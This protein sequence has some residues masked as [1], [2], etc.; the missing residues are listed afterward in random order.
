MSASQGF[1]PVRQDVRAV[2]QMPRRA[3]LASKE[4]KVSLRIIKEPFLL[5]VPSNLAVKTNSD[6]GDVAEG[7]RTHGFIDVGDRGS[8][9]LDAIQKVAHVVGTPGEHQ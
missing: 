1:E 3:H 6:F 5:R 7:V 2:L 4:T 9:T 8:T